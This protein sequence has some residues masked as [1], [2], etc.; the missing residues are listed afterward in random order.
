[1]IDFN[2]GSGHPEH[3][4]DIG[5]LINAALDAALVEENAKQTPRDYLG[6]SGV[7]RNCSRQIQ[8][9]FTN[10]PKDPGKGFNGKTLRKFRG[11]H[12][13]EDDTIDIMR[14]AGFDIK[15]L[16]KHGRQ[17]GFED[18]D[19][20]YKGHCDG[21][22]ISAPVPIKTPCLFEHKA[23]G[24]K[25]FGKFIKQGVRRANGTYYGQLQEYMAYLQLAENPALFCVRNTD[26]QEFYWE[27]VKFDAAE[28]QRLA[29][30]AYQIITDTD[31][32]VL[33]PRAA[34]SPDHFE[35]KWCDWSER[36]W[37]DG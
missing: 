14:L 3:G 35:C 36:C 2:H 17:F 16:D 18:L 26:T 29:D 15:N 5:D 7:A 4:K 33:Q 27:L 12:W 24:N 37:K 22:V 6:V 31:A 34:A 25:S 30:R 10:T 8:Y 28:A 32:G 1:M 13:Y 9:D 21:V 20:R 19:G 23:V 11:G